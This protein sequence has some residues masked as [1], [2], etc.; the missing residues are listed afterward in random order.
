MN[1]KIAL[2]V[3]ACVVAL[4]CLPTDIAMMSVWA[5][6][7]AV[8]ASQYITK[9]GGPSS[10]NEI[11]VAGSTVL[12]GGT[13]CYVNANGWAD[14]DTNSGANTFGGVVKETLDNSAGSNGDVK[15]DAH[16]T[17]AFLLPGSGFSQGDVGSKAYGVDNF[18]VSTTST[19]NTYIGTIVGFKSATEVWVELDP[20]TP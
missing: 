1:T 19:N 10:L 7:M 8:T 16:K 17:G 2:A 3:G 9:K 20:Q 14:D 15:G 18:T 13:L 12:Y 4:A 5:V 11:R 6:G